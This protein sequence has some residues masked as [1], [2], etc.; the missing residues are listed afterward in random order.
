MEWIIENIGTILVSLIVLAVIGGAAAVVIRNRRS[1]KGRCGCGCA[2]CAMRAQCHGQS[3][4]RHHLMLYYLLIKSKT[5]RIF[6]G[7]RG[8]AYLFYMKCF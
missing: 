1:G 2:N 6:G 3:K 7:S 5:A 8:F 4:K